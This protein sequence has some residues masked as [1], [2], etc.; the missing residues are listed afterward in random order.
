M[1]ELIK[2][3]CEALIEEAEA[4]M[5]NTDRI[6]TTLG[7]NGPV[8]A[9]Q[10]FAINRLDAVE[11]IQNLTVRLTNVLAENPVGTLDD[12]MKASEDNA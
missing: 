7:K 12:S 11:H 4:V 6:T 9:V 1:D 2:S 10:T 8:E 5:K 3:L